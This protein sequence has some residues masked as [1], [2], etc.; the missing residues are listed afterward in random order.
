MTR[1]AFD[2]T[3]VDPNNGRHRKM[4]DAANNMNED[5]T[6][7]FNAIFPRCEV[8]CVQER[9]APSVTYVLESGS[10]D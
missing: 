4:M 3:I 8:V 9:T 7:F 10:L 5:G 6:Y 2:I 1:R